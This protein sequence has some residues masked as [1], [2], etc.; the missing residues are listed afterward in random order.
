MPGKP[1]YIIFNRIHSAAISPKEL[2]G[3]EAY[4]TAIYR[5]AS[6]Q[7]LWTE[8]PWAPG[9]TGSLHLRVVIL[10]PEM[11]AKKCKDG[12][13]GASVMG[14]AIDGATD[15]SGRIGSLDLAYVLVGGTKG[16]SAR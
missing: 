5:A 10:S 16:L 1:R 3:A 7:T 9:E 8:T 12:H 6:I 14:T 2:A 11:I 15:G 4:A 13:L